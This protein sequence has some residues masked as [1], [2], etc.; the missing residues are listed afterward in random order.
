MAPHQ[1]DDV[2]AAIGASGPQAANHQLV[3]Q[4]VIAHHVE[5]VTAVDPLLDEI[6][7]HRRQPCVAIAHQEAADRRRGDCLATRGARISRR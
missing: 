3:V 4:L 7:F 5:G 2:D 1:L 6:G